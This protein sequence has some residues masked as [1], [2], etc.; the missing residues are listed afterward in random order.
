MDT[1]GLPVM[2]LGILRAEA[3]VAVLD[4]EQTAIGQRDAV[5]VPA[6][7]AEHLFGPLHG[8]LTVHDP[9][10]RPHRLGDGQIGT[11]LAHE[12]QEEPSKELREGLDGDQVGR[13]GRPP[14]GPI[15]GD[16]T[17][18]YEAVHMWMVGQGAGPGVQHTQDPDQTTDVMRIRGERDARVG[19]GSEPDVVQVLLVAADQRPQV[20]GQGEDDM[21][22]GDGQEFLT[23]LFQ[24]GFGV[25]AMTRGTTP[26]AAGVVDV[27]FL[28]TVIALE[29]LPA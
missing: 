17:G 23:P 1:Y 29:Q 27:V 14:L 8:R 13:T 26:V 10:G 11:L 3:D 16:P 6:Q 21:K 2:V 24:P 19:R 28:A 4:R 25:Q 7:V 18:G 5:D 15:H 22:G 20:S 12:I 9:R